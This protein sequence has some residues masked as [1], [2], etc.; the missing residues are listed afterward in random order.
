MCLRLN[1]VD[2]KKVGGISIWGTTIL[3]ATSRTGDHCAPRPL[4]E[5]NS[6]PCTG[7]V[8]PNS[9]TI[10]SQE[11]PRQAANCWANSRRRTFQ[12]SISSSQ[13]DQFRVF[14][15]RQLLRLPFGL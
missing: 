1:V 10:R 9:V 14:R 12:P 11:T 3:A 13:G 5:P 6:T 2:R 4:R 15:R 7:V 8:S